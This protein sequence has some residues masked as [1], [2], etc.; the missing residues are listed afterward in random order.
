MKIKN[1]LAY[2]ILGGLLIYSII[3]R[4]YMIILCFIALAIVLLILEKVI[5]SIIFKIEKM[6]DKGRPD[7]LLPVISTVLTEEQK[8]YILKRLR[9][10]NGQ[11]EIDCLVE[12][13]IYKVKYNELDESDLEMLNRLLKLRLKISFLH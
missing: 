7:K 13:F 10:L 1:I 12:Q 2:F 9:K 8:D 4:Q 11:S 6:I 3:T 5:N